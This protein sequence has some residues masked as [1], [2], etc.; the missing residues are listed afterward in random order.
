[1]LA[2]KSVKEVLDLLACGFPINM[3]CEGSPITIRSFDDSSK[4][5]LTTPVYIGDT[6]FPKSVRQSLSNTPAFAPSSILTYLLV[7]ESKF[8]ITLN[9]VGKLGDLSEEDLRKILEEF[10]F[11]AQEWRL[12]FEGHEKRDLL[13]L[14]VK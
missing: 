5:T 3:N 12:Y 4:L 13:P 7:D 10:S 11:R 14:R 9:F 8:C 1:M 6:Y 2:Q